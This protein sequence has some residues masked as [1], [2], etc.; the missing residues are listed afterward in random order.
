MSGFINSEERPSLRLI[1]LKVDSKGRVSIPAEI[2]KSFGLDKSPYLILT[3]DLRK[4]SI[5]LW[6]AWCNG[7]IEDC[8]N[9]F[10]KK[11]DQKMLQK[12][13]GPGSKP[14]SGPKRGD[15]YE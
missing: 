13:S 12:S 4:N 11:L 15:K 2:R 5:V 3:F 8:G 10:R 6:P 9:L 14:G 7:S 1:S